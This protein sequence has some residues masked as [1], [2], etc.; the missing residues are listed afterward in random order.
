MPTDGL[1][2]SGSVAPES[3]SLLQTLMARLT[4]L[5]RISMHSEPAHLREPGRARTN[6][7]QRFCR[8]RALSSAKSGRLAHSV[9]PGRGRCSLKQQVPDTTRRRPNQPQFLG[10]AC[11]PLALEVLSKC[12]IQVLSV[13]EGG[14]RGSV[15]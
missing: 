4:C 2:L 13:T 1:T 10:A 12:S 15:S 14:G 9:A 3:T 8:C 6:K 7:R 5:P 11:D